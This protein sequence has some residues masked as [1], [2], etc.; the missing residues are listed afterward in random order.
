MTKEK[1]KQWI[2]EMEEEAERQSKAEKGL[3]FFRPKYR[4]RRGKRSDHQVLNRL[5]LC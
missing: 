1:R 5:A 2:R 4:V 3:N